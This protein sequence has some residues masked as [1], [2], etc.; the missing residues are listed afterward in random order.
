MVDF[1]YISLF[2]TKNG[3]NSGHN[4]I[5]N[6]DASIEEPIEDSGSDEYR[7]RHGYLVHPCPYFVHI[8]N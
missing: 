8:V 4:G 2:V 3:H 5:S 6:H 1:G 7:L